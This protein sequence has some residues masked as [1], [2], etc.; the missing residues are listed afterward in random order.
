M[1]PIF[2]LST[3]FVCL[4]SAAAVGADDAAALLKTIQSAET[5]DVDR[6]NA[7]QKIGDVAGDEAVEPLASFLGDK[8]WS[9]YA[10]YAFQKME[11]QVV[12]D[13]LTEALDTLEGDLRLGV[14][15]TIG[16]RRDPNA[17]APLAKLLADADA[18][19]ADSAA[20]ALGWIGTPN[21]A[22]ALTEAFDA[23]TDA[24]RKESLG[25][26]L[27]LAGQRL[28]RT[29]NNQAAIRVF[30]LLREA[31]L[32]KACRIGATKNAILAR[33]ARGVDL[34]V[35]Q[36]K[37]SD[38]DYF[39]TGLAASRVLP[40]ES[41][42]K[43]LAGLLGT[44]SSPDR[45]V[46]L[47]QAMKDRGDRLALPA[48]LATLESNSAAV[49]LAAVDAIG[50]LGDGSSVPILLSVANDATN[51]AV[52]DS[53]VALQGADV[54]PALM[55]AAEPPN[56]SAVAL[57]ALGRRRAKEAVDLFFQLSAADRPAISE[58]A[59]AALGMTAP[60]DRFLDL[61]ALFKTAK[62][63]A[64]KATIQ[65]AIH[66]A[67]FRSTRP[68]ACAEA[69]CAMI[70]SAS[71]ADRDFL[72]EQVRTAGGV[73]AVARMREFA[74]GSDEALQDAATNTL[75]RWLSADAAPVLL[76]VAQGD[77]KF[78]DRALGGYIRIF[79]QFELPEAERVA[80]A[81]K[82]LKVARRS[83][84]RNAAISAMTRFPCVGTFEL[85]LGQL[86]APGSEAAAA[87]A[88]L[89]IAR[90]VLDLDP[91]KGKAGLERLIDANISKSVTD[92]ARV[93]LQ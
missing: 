5:A 28:A 1:R 85:A 68:D 32:S 57:N 79:R 47:I 66:G 83:N 17:V 34:M 43:G 36:L 35:E 16:R 78:A 23:A 73:K 30:D 31:D 84:E 71:A 11:G 12:T 29:G 82:A 8:T 90:T 4:L 60:Q 21:A 55:K 2:T 6:A 87:K 38:L 91:E 54:N 22:A 14:I 80:M 62:S 63:D 33:G 13:A 24:K 89:T 15:G 20:V 40:G 51:E 72:F 74:T 37:S 59:I 69:L 86:D 81:A 45:K 70:P 56:T 76:E 65:N 48:V 25:S 93:L 92:S 18:E 44:E 61:L 10:R 49:Q 9:H 41:A 42:T 52:L 58:Q 75:G 50:A 3:L 39:Q 27:L 19:V 53:L 88:V 7:F 46:L 26:A 77:G 67:V 64:R